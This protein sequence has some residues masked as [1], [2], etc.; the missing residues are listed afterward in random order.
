MERS[1]TFAGPYLW[2]YV[3]FVCLDKVYDFL[4]FS[5][6]LQVNPP[7]AAAPAHL[8]LPSTSSAYFNDVQDVSNAS[9][10]PEV[11]EYPASHGLDGKCV[12]YCWNVGELCKPSQ[13]SRVYCAVQLTDKCF[14]V[15]KRSYFDVDPYH[16]FCI[17]VTSLLK[18]NAKIYHCLFIYIITVT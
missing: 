14:N 18:I 2:L 11:N 5:F 6:V 8:A 7:G 3:F 4:P 15:A 10:N 13:I 1:F 12:C 16:L 9:W 17:T